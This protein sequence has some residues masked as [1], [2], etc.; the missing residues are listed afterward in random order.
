VHANLIVP[1]PGSGIHC[2]IAVLGISSFWRRPRL[3]AGGV[4]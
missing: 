2:A 4:A 1:E 3:M